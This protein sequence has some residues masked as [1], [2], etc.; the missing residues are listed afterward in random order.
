MHASYGR[1]V[2]N[3]CLYT[4][5]RIKILGGFHQ[6]KWMNGIVT[7]PTAGQHTE[8]EVH[9]TLVTM[10]TDLHVVRNVDES[11]HGGMPTTGG[12]RIIVPSLHSCPSPP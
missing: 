5:V 1:G 7:K 4:V 2:F 9:L 6:Q 11:R 10:Q 12:W 8:V 3:Y